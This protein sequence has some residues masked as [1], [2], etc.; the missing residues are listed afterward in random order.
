M[1]NLLWDLDGTVVDSMPVIAK[2]INETCLTYGKPKLPFADLR[3]FI[4]PELGESL[5]FL[6]ELDQ[7]E[8]ILEA[9]QIYRS[10][11]VREM[12]NSPLFDG[13]VPV[14]EHFQRC[15]A[16][17]FIATAKYQDYARQ[18]VEALE[19]QRFFSAIYGS[20]SDGRLGDKKDLLAH[21]LAEETLLPAQTFMIGDTRFDIEAGRY[22]NLSTI[23]A[24]WGYGGEP[25][26]VSAGAH[27]LAN[28]PHDLPELIRQAANS[29]C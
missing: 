27:Y 18:I 17:Q 5:A 10:F 26:L 23:G 16:R 12:L 6:L 19:I 24:L 13:L 21:L 8:D 15:G 11:Y 22:H 1:L 29:G 7:R 2:S 4:G 28:Q 14:L 3:P 25:S 9:K 20:H